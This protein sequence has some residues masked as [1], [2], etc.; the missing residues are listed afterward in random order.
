MNY[1]FPVPTALSNLY[2][3]TIDKAEA[4]AAIKTQPGIVRWTDHSDYEE[5]HFHDFKILID[6]YLAGKQTFIDFSNMPMLYYFTGKISPSYFY[7]NPLTIH[8]EYLQ[9]KFISDLKEYDA[10]L[11]VF[12]AFPENWWDNVDGVAN[13]MRHYRLAEFFYQHYQPFVIADKLCVWK[14]K[15]FNPEMKEEVLYSYTR[16]EDSLKAQSDVIRQTVKSPEGK[17]HL[18]KIHWAENVP[19]VIQRINDGDTGLKADFINTIEHLAYYILKDSETEFS[20]ELKNNE[21]ILSVQLSQNDFIPDFYSHCP[22]NDD[23]KLLPSIWAKYDAALKAEKVIAAL[24]PNPVTLAGNEMSFFNFNSHIDKSTGNTV[25]ISLEADND[26][27]LS[28]ELMYGSKK[29]GFMG[30]FKFTLPPG[31]GT[32]NF[33]IRI[34]SQFNWYNPGVDYLALVS[35]TGPAVTVK[36]IELLKAE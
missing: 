1:K 33:A 4:F 2:S 34:S 8:N 27:E 30:L 35:K 25:F 28:I 7:Q 31:R 5:T 16:S 32:R 21:N 36:K 14:R 9:K 10:P 6:K 13:T 17:K 26:E 20:F 18:L 29:N 23:L 15:D 24:T 22:Q 3:K 19:D 11:I 12:S